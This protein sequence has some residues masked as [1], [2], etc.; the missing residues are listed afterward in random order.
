MSEMEKEISQ[1]NR[2]LMKKATTFVKY[3]TQVL[4]KVGR[5]VQY[6]AK[7]IP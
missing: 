4:N 3:H 5:V 6:F 2:L 7:S 1:P